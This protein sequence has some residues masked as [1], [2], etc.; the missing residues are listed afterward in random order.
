MQIKPMGFLLNLEKFFHFTCPEK[1]DVH[2]VVTLLARKWML[3]LGVPIYVCEQL[4]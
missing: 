1:Y 2:L 3:S 4:F